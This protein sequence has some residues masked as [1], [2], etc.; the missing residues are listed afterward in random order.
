MNPRYSVVLFDADNTL[1]D[2]D[3]AED[4]ALDWLLEELALPPEEKEHYLTVNRALWHQFDL[5]QIAAEDLVVE[6]FRRF[7]HE[8]GRQADP[9]ELNRAYLAHVGS[10]PALLP[11][12]EALCRALEPF[13]TLAIVTNGMPSVQHSRMARSGIA[14][15][16]SG[17]FISGEMGCRK[18]E[19][20]FFEQVFHGLGLG[21]ED[22]HRTVMVGDNLLSDIKGGRDFGLDT[23]WFAPGGGVPGPE[24]PQPTY[25]ARSF[26]DIQTRILA[27]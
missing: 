9:A 5:G 23:I 27:Q 6:R 24:D 11:G 12:A 2:F 17:L 3:R 1:F 8:T 15:L 18:P 10:C 21:E 19:R 16:F 20:Q 13:C 7:L 14:E 4:L 25:I 22:K 26:P